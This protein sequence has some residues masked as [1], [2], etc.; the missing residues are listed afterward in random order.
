M[1]VS[2]SFDIEPE[3][4]SGIWFDRANIALIHNGVRSLVEPDSGRLYNASGPFGS[5]VTEDLSGWADIK[6]TWVSSGFSA[7]ALDSVSLAGEIIQLDIAYGTDELEDGDGFW[8]DQLTLTDV[9]IQLPDSQSDACAPEC[10]VDQDCE[11]GLFCNGAETCVDGACQAGGDPCPGQSCDEAGDTCGP[12]Q[13][14]ADCEDGLFCNGVETC[15]A[16]ACQDGTLVDCADAFACTA[17]SCNEGSDSCNNL[18]NDAL[19][20]NGV[21]CDGSETCSAVSGC[22]AGTPV[23]CDDG[24]DCTV[25]SCDVVND[26]CDNVTND[27]LCDNGVFCDGPE[28]CDA[29]LDC[30]AAGGVVCPNQSCDEDGDTCVGQALL[31]SGSL[32]V[33]GTAAT[34]SLTNTYVSPVVVATVQYSNSTTPVVTRVSAVT[35]NSFKV[36]LQ[37][38]GGGAVATEIVSWLVVEKGTWTID[39]VKVEAQTYLS[40]VPDEDDSWV[41]QAQTYGQSYTVPVVL[42][43]VMTENDSDFSAFWAQGATRTDPPAAAVLTT[44]KHVGEDDDEDRLDE[45]VGF[46]VFEAGHGTIGGVEYEAKLGVDTVKGVGDSPPYTYT[47]SSSF[48]SAPSIAVLTMAG[49]DGF[50]GGWAQTHGATLAT[51]TTLFLSIDEDQIIDTERN[52][53]TEQV[54]YFVLGGTL[55]VS[56]CTTDP[57][58]DDDLFCNGEETCSSGSCQAGTAPDCR[59]SGFDCTVDTCNEENNNCDH[60]PDDGLCLDDGLFC[61]AAETCD[62][63]AGQCVSPGD[64]C[65]GTCDEDNDVCIGSGTAGSLESG[66]VDVGAALVTV[67]LTNTYVSPVV[68]ATVQYFNSTTPVVTRVSAVT[69]TSFKVRLQSPAGNSVATEIVSWLVVEKGTWTIDGVKV[70]AQTYL[71]TVT[72]ED[73]S[74]VGQAQTYGQSYT[75][76]VVLGQVMTENDSDFS[77]FWAKGAS[78]TDPPSATVLTTG[79]HV[80]EDGDED[81]LDETVGFIVFEAGHGTIGGVEYEAKLGVDTVKGVGDSPPYTYTFSSSFSSA[82]SIAV[83]TMAGMDGFNGGWAQTHGATVSIP[84]QSRGL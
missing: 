66:S 21:F 24:V 73:D 1:A 51:T 23:N 7:T 30:Q 18:T 26:E 40:T 16:G 65:P 10:D 71:S 83:L 36:R 82:P 84:R 70:E 27:G 22:Q 9:E 58:C 39:G 41:G 80:G 72:D 61:T 33:G 6:T 79:K 17:D 46:I 76:P 34:V 52:H 8:F 20:D 59:A 48:S 60:V 77:V 13:V 38:P 74:W 45:T 12:C 2:T 11:D 47:F 35:T 44:G 78:Q 14:D 67:A 54:G 31:E 63:E 49:M 5:C 62:V 53:A 3:F 50:N 81:R 4:F 57:D 29:V 69:A 19:C 15:V 32:S 64:S 43:Q 56:A 75:V 25:D 55:V 28:T 68:V 42:G 37:T